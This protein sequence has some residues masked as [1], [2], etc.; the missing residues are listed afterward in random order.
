[1]K[2]KIPLLIIL[3]T[4]VLYLYFNPSYVMAINARYNLAKGDF[5]EA[6]YLAEESLL[7]DPHNR[8]AME[9]LS[10]SKHK[11]M[12]QNFLRE[13]SERKSEIEQ[14]LKQ[15]MSIE[16]KKRLEWLSKM[17]LEQFSSI[18]ESPSEYRKERVK[19]EAWFSQLQ[20]ELATLAQP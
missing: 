11:N 20:R 2:F 1:M 7:L 5:K 4:F 13:M 8:F 16:H 12:W 3:I 17:S 10:Q 6:R 18:G 9:V 15:R 19:L 14:S